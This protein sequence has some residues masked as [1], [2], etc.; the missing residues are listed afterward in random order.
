MAKI[1]IGTTDYVAKSITQYLA[2]PLAEAFRTTGTQR[3]YAFAGRLGRVLMDCA[4]L[5]R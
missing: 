1:T 2:Q 4:T 5:M 3:I